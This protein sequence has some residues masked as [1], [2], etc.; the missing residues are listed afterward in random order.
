MNKTFIIIITVV[1]IGAVIYF[2]IPSNKSAIAPVL[3]TQSSLNSNINIKDF[4]FYP[5][6]LNIKTGTKV[7]WTN[8]DNIPH[9]IVSDSG[10]LLNSGTIALGQSWSFTFS[11]S[12]T[13]NYHCSIHPMMKG[14]IVVTN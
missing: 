1:I 8:N 4:A 13:V 3:N 5:S 9:T 14:V 6:S 2:L 12:N 7:T 10:N 11:N